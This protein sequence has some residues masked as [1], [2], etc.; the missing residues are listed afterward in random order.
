VTRRTAT[1]RVRRRPAGNGNT[2]G[3]P[4][5]T[6]KRKLIREN[7]IFVRRDAFRIGPVSPCV[8]AA[9]HHFPFRTRNKQTRNTSPNE[10]FHWNPPTFVF[11]H[12][13]FPR[14][15]KSGAINRRRCQRLKQN[16]VVSEIKRKT[17]SVSR[18]RKYF[19]TRIRT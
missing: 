16:P 5:S 14:K 17:V 8:T 9:N 1:P 11:D 19:E 3:A 13:S 7:R 18:R 15:Y 10:S 12:F 6:E 4:F 2:Y